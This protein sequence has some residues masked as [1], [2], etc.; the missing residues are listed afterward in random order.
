MT[1]AAHELEAEVLQ[2]DAADRARILERLIESFDGPPQVQDA[3]LDEALRREAE[4]TLGRATLISGEDVQCKSHRLLDV[5]AQ[6]EP[7][8]E[9][10]EL[11][12]DSPL[13]A[14]DA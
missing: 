4:V 9:E 12:K 5:L 2:L 1:M 3:W 13:Q 8:E 10:I 7:L 6:W 14:R 11:P